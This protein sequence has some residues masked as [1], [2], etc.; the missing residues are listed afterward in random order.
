MQVGEIL[1]NT[2]PKKHNTETTK[3][4]RGFSILI[5]SLFLLTH[6]ESRR[7]FE[8]AGEGSA[9]DAVDPDSPESEA[10]VEAGCVSGAVRPDVQAR[11]PLRFFC[12]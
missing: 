11:H 3:A 4:R 9:L 6:G 2:W 1:S 7:D 8:S 5:N 10:F 12:S